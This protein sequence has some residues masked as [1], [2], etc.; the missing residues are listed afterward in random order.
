MC[1]YWGD[2]RV[3]FTYQH[4]YT[5]FRLKGEEKAQHIQFSLSE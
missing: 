2:D 5:P 1:K 3:D 4:F